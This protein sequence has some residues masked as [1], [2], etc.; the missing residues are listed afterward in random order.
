MEFL[1]TIG[2][3]EA[4]TATVANLFGNEGSNI[5]AASRS[6][7]RRYG[8]TKYQQALS[9][10]ARFTADVYKG[11]RPIW[12]FQEAMSTDDFPLLFGTVLDRQLLGSYTEAPYSWSRYAKR[13]TVRDF[14]TVQRN[15]MNG[16]E[17]V[18]STV[19]ESGE[20][21]E[22]SLAEGQYTYSVKKYG[23]RVPLTWETMINDDL[24]AFRDI[25]DRLGKSARRTEEKFVTE[26]Y[27]DTTGPKAATFTAI[28]GNP[29]LSITA[30]QSAMS[31]LLT[32]V[33]ADGEPITVG[34]MTLVVPPQLQVT[35]GNILN[36]T[37][38]AIGTVGQGADAAPTEEQRLVTAN[39]IRGQGII[40]SVTNFY[41]PIVA[42]TNGDTSWFLMAQPSVGRPAMEIGFL[43]GY[44]TPQLFRKS[45][46][47]ISMGGGPT[48]PMDGD[49]D[50]D[51]MHYKVRHVLGG[52]IMETKS[53]VASNGTGS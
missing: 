29:A 39:W 52:A 46:N 50:T 32:Q 45:S 22:A 13:A 34:S 11:T 33:D 18:L 5:N 49:F 4:Q 44:E 19:N 30:L 51:H 36:A 24:D 26:L 10:A 20:Y 37:S 1:E 31:V 42:T 40:D 28:S 17:G 2:Q 43:R 16:L 12:H 35:A 8:P 25:P 14:R 23:R 3:I 7:A 21:T 38:L 53:I 15:F 47:A 41:I 27:V 6:L 48:D 9:E